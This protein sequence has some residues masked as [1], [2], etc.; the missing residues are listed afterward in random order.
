[1]H[2]GRGV[3]ATTFREAAADHDVVQ[4]DDQSESADGG[5]NWQG[6]KPGRR[7]RE[8]KHIGLARSPI[9][10]KKCRC[11]LPIEIARALNGNVVQEAVDIMAEAALD[12]TNS[13][14]S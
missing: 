6:G 11:P 2:A 9:S 7:K 13:A 10:V 14:A 3:N 12:Q 1:M 4:P 5:N 8:T